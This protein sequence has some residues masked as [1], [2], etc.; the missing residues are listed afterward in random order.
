MKRWP[1]LN[2]E[3]Q[4]DDKWYPNQA[5]LFILPKGNPFFYCLLTL[6]NWVLNGSIWTIPSGN[7]MFGGKAANC[8]EFTEDL[9]IEHVFFMTRN[10][11]LGKCCGE[12]HEV[13]K[14]GDMI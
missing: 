3:K 10:W 2:G 14:P 13:N 9:L 11:N 7:Q 4:I 8:T 1:S 6:E 5:P 12:S